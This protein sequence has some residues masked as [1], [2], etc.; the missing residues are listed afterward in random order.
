[1]ILCRRRLYFERGWCFVQIPMRWRRRRHVVTDDGD[2]A[3]TVPC[4]R[5]PAGRHAQRHVTLTSRG[6]LVSVMSCVNLRTAV[7]RVPDDFV[8][9]VDVAGLHTVVRT[10]DHREPIGCDAQL[11]G[12]LTGLEKCP[13]NSEG[14]S[15]GTSGS[16]CRITSVCVKRLWSLPHW[17]TQWYMHGFQTFRTL[18]FSYPGVSYL[19]L[20]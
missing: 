17:W 15:G 1:M 12:T 7:A 4:R 11:V 13:R 6:P 19:R 14:V 16:G 3:S 2:D 8:D 9:V 5:G 18:T 20:L 10:P